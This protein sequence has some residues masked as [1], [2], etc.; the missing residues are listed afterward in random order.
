MSESRNK[1]VCRYLLQTGENNRKLERKNIKMS[2][3]SNGV[4][5]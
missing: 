1:V 2:K 4:C 5:T 3:N